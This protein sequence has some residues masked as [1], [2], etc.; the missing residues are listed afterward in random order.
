MTDQDQNNERET[1]RRHPRYPV[2]GLEGSFVFSTDVRII[3]LSVEGVGI[4][5]QTSLTVGRRYSLKVEREDQRLDLS[6][7]VAWCRLTGTRRNPAGDVVPI[8]RAGIRFDDVLTAKALEWLEFIRKTAPV[9]LESRVFG[10]F[11][12]K[13]GTSGSSIAEIV[14]TLGST[15][16]RLPMLHAENTSSPATRF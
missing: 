6:G 3:D 13:P 8:Y 12:V 16:E 2:D 11:T 10:R 7:Q 4:E 14:T 15:V 1:R 5:T 9:R